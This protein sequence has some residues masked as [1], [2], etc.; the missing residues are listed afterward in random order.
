MPVSRRRPQSLRIPTLGRTPGTSESLLVTKRSG[1]VRF[2]L[3][4]RIRFGTILAIRGRNRVHSKEPVPTTANI[5]RVSLTMVI[6]ISVVAVLLPLCMAIGCDMATMGM[7]G[8]S[9]LGFSSKCAD[10]MA[11]GAQ[12]A[13][14]PGSPQSL[15]ML[16][17][18]AFCM[19]FVLAAPQPI[20]RFL[21]VVAED[22]PAPPEDPRGVR[23]II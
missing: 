12:A 21:R 3:F 19:A 11:S 2:A 1:L 15:I 14:A 16:L 23:L 7:T 6:I 9:T 22:P 5:D 13:I 10:V 4:S 20:R 8:S 18:A 17:V